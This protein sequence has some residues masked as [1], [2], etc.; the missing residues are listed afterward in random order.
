MNEP[1]LSSINIKG[2]RP[3]YD[4]TAAVNA[5]EVL[6]GANGSGKSA[7]FQF[8]KF[9][10][11]G[12]DHII[13]PEVIIGGAGQQIF[14][15]ESEKIEW[16]IDYCLSSD[17]QIKYEG[18]L[19]GP[20]GRIKITQETVNSVLED[21]AYSFSF[22]SNETMSENKFL[23]DDNILH[24][25]KADNIL[26]SKDIVLSVMNKIDISKEL[27]AGIGNIITVTVLR[28]LINR[29][30]FFS[31]NNVATQKIRKPAI[32]E[33]EP[34]FDEDCGNLSSILYYIESEHPRVFQEIQMII[35]LIVPGFE[36]IKVKARGGPGEV[37]AYWRETGIDRELSLA[38]LSDG[39]LHLLCWATICLHPTPPSL[40]C[41]DEPDQ[42]LHPRALPIL[43][44]LF[45]KASD[46]T[47]VFVTT[48]SSYF[49][50]QFDISDIAVMRKE[51]GKAI[52]RKPKDS[53]I[54]CGMLDDFGT[55]EIEY[56]HYSDQL[57]NFS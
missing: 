8:L 14:N 3:F 49:L 47:Q 43:A 4:F 55:E 54:L 15:S 38:D 10:R 31:S 26:L 22:T 28:S 34:E 20:I 30:R 36:G 53:K 29:W 42:G 45:Q 33:Q 52:F 46:R 50:S 2:F 6:V 39:I 16:G 41:I 40:I 37:I 35:R 44:G 5:L 18:I 7:F 21:K 9:L 11:D 24:N 17:S 25:I 27:D 13:P 48:H 23:P 56:L 32:I 12:T 51:K 1:R 57:E 19:E